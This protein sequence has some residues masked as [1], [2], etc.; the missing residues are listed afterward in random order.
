MMGNT[1]TNIASSVEPPLY[2]VLLIDI[3]NDVKYRRVIGQYIYKNE[4][5]N[6]NYLIF[7][8]RSKTNCGIGS[9]IRS[10]KKVI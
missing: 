3:D 5:N 8:R 4:M 2:T 9:K 10:T 1:F 6:N 7:R